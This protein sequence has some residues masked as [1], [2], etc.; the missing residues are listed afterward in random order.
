[1]LLPMEPEEVGQD[2][3]AVWFRFLLPSQFVSRFLHSFLHLFHGIHHE[4]HEF[5]GLLGKASSSIIFGPLGA[6]GLFGGLSFLTSGM[7]CLFSFSLWGSCSLLCGGLSLL[8]FPIGCGEL[9]FFFLLTLPKLKHVLEVSCFL[10]SAF[11]NRIG[12]ERD[13]LRSRILGIWINY[14]WCLSN[15]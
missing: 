13:F 7:S 8:L 12:I 10:P 5:Q 11:L 4:G 1:M 2:F 9:R 14:L 6:G 15:L 3:Q